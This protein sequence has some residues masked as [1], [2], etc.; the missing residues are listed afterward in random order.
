MSIISKYTDLIREGGLGEK[1]T[2]SAFNIIM[3]GKSDLK[4]LILFLKTLNDNEINAE[5]VLGAVKIM[6]DKMVS[7]NI[8]KNSI[9]TCGTGGDGKF[10]LNISTAVAF[11]LSA[12]DIPVA[13]HGNRSITSNCGSADV[14]KSLGI[15]ID[16]PTEMLSECIEETKI[17]FMFA[18]HH[19]PAMKH[20]SEARQIL[21]KEGIKTI[22][23]ILGPLLNPGNV[24]EQIIG[25]FNEDVQSIYKEVF[26]QDNEKKAFIVYGY[27]GMDEVSTEGINSIVHNNNLLKFDP[28]D[29]GMK[30]P[31]IKELT[32]ETPEYNS[33]RIIDIFSGNKDSF[34]EIVSVNAALGLVLNKNLE[35]NKQNILNCINDVKLVLNDG[36]ALNK[37]KQLKEFTNR[38]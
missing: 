22:F 20:V 25:V 3:E 14:L 15:N 11:V 8:P 2:S 36:S 24:K 16:M 29:I 35:L 28:A 19:H 21:G 37:V 31:I 5:H 38:K 9:D 10:S 17:C 12:L 18:P 32:G 26:N 23:N 4:D 7:V 6:R 1:E 13:K 27:D 33:S 34:Y 30:R